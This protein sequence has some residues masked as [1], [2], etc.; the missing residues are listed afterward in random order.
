[1]ARTFSIACDLETRQYVWSCFNNQQQ[2]VQNCEPVV[3]SAATISAHFAQRYSKWSGLLLLQPSSGCLGRWLLL[4]PRLQNLRQIAWQPLSVK[5]PEIV[6]LNDSNF[7][8]L[9]Q[10]CDLYWTVWGYF[11]NHHSGCC[12]YRILEVALQAVTVKQLAQ[13]VVI[14]PHSPPTM[15]SFTTGTTAMNMTKKGYIF[16]SEYSGED[17]FVMASSLAEATGKLPDS[18]QWDDYY[19][20]SPRWAIVVTGKS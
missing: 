8:F 12:L 13:G 18:F 19:I 7:W 16:T 11:Y 15:I 14:R 3:L 5:L 4:W 10:H 2:M 1:M 9:W 17:K 6:T 20:A